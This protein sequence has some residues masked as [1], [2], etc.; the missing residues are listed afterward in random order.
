MQVPPLRI[1]RLVHTLLMSLELQG[2]VTTSSKAA[3][4]DRLFYSLA[5]Y[6]GSD[7]LD[8]TATLQASI[9][10]SGE[11][12]IAQLVG[13]APDGEGGGSQCCVAFVNDVDMATVLDSIDMSQG[14]VVDS[15]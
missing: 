3:Q 2:K 1:V 15:A 12:L 7:T 8:L 6:V 14:S 9:L 10:K 13:Q 11:S 4:L 5:R